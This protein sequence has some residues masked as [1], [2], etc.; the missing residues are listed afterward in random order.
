MGHRQ[1]LNTLPAAERQALVELILQYLN[2]AIVAAHTTITHSGEHIL[3]GHRQY[4]E[5]L[6]SLPDIN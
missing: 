6:V 1:N 4:I 5:E 2:D 3:T